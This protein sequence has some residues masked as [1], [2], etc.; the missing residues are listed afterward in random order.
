MRRL[1][2]GLLAGLV[3]LE[4][5]AGAEDPVAEEAALT[6]ELA[7]T[8]EAP[9]PLSGL[10]AVPAVSPPRAPALPEPTRLALG[11]HGELWVLERHALP[12]AQ[13]EI[14]FAWPGAVASTEDQLAA[15]LA[16]ALLGTGSDAR[17]AEALAVAMDAL[18]AS[19]DLGMSGARLWASLSVPS[20]N[21]APALEHL[22]EA[23]GATHFSRRETRRVVKRWADWKA[24]THLD[25][26][27]IHRRALNHAWFPEGHPSR[28]SASVAEVRALRAQ[29]AEALVQRT[30]AEGQLRVVAVGDVQAEALAAL[31]NARLG[32]L[33]GPG[34]PARLSEPELT[35]KLWLVDRP[36]F[37]A[38][39]LSVMSPGLSREDPD[40]PLAALLMTVI[41]GTFTSRLVQDLRETRGLV[42]TLSAETDAWSGTG[43]TRVDMELATE[44]LLEA[45]EVVEGHLDQLVL[46][47]ITEE[48]LALARGV[49]LSEVGAQLETNGSAAAWLSDLAVRGSSVAADQAALARVEA[50]TP[51]ELDALAAR[52]F[53]PEGRVWVITG[54]R[55]LLEPALER[56]GR[57]PDRLVSARIVSE[58]R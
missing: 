40:Y 3:L 36:G 51:A 43:R 19:W 57:V 45:L 32:A 29:D 50:A 18:G 52:L 26:R 55:D 20:E 37:S 47:G 1:A 24:E 48:E 22:V 14:S 38:A 11:E 17:G 15:G 23:L 56:A 44:Q 39:E 58:E 13:L 42:Y 41:G 2:W 27:R 46:G 8:Q 6:E 35:P 53:A 4:A 34:A 12:L 7:L 10:A 25:I 30:L 54:D 21:L 5:A 33:G 31:L 16:G 28:H 49:L 9:A